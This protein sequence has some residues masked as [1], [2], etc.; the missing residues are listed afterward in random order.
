LGGT[1]VPLD[2]GDKIW[3]KQSTKDGIMEFITG[4]GQKLKNVHDE[5]KCKGEKLCHSQSLRS[6]YEGLSASLEG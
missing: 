2:K 5:S 3:Y 4:T 1:K 6:S